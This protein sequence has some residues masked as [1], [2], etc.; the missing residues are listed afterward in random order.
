MLAMLPIIGPIE[1]LIMGLASLLVWGGVITF[2]VFVV[3]ALRRKTDQDRTIATLV[4]ENRSLREALG[5][6]Q[7]AEV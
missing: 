4:E 2:V 7:D 6:R 1:L 5:K 3:R